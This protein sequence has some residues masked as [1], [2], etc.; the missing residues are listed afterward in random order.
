MI[1]L[2]LTPEQLD[3]LLK[4]NFAVATVSQDMQIYRC[5][6]VQAGDRLCH[7]RGVT[8]NP[9]CAGKTVYLTMGCGL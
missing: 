5:D 3:S 4:T 6:T 1:K 7:V 8:D 2:E 9:H